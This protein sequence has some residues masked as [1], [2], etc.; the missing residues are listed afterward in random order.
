M[1]APASSIRPSWQSDSSASY[2]NSTSTRSSLS[3]RLRFSGNQ[4]DSWPPRNRA[5]N[6][7]NSF[8]PRV[9]TMSQHRL[10]NDG[11]RGERL[12][13]YSNAR[14]QPADAMMETLRSVQM[15]GATTTAQRVHF[16][17]L[18][19]Q[20]HDLY[21]RAREEAE[22]S[23]ATIAQRQQQALAQQRQ[24][25]QEQ[26][27][28]QQQQRQAQTSPPQH[29]VY[30][31]DCRSC[32]AFLT[33]RGMKVGFLQML[34]CIA[35]LT[36]VLLFD[37]ERL[38]KCAGRLTLATTHYALLDRRH[39]QLRPPVCTITDGRYDGECARGA[40]RKDVRLPH[41]DTRLLRLRQ[42]RRIPHRLSLCA[43]H[44]QRC[45][46]PA[47]LQWPPHRLALQR[48]FRSRASLH[49]RR[50]RRLVCATTAERLE[51]WLQARPHQCK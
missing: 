15:D 18:Q 24:Q 2:A 34:I 7:S 8:R 29:R 19:R 45:Q 31:I 30:L 12:R 43:V 14:Q 1:V 40:H 22:A 37:L 39:A 47:Q 41:T 3:A 21:R 48:D 10:A 16:Q 13:R 23:L 6:Y 25:Q 33:D 51:P 26:V 11:N 32:G 46:A 50:G 20:Y 44:K 35:L 9:T 49:S 28:I 42:R 38:L 5:G 4:D 27:A 36:L 17:Q